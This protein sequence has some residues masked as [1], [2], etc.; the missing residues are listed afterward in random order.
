MAQKSPSEILVNAKEK[1]VTQKKEVGDENEM[2][3]SRE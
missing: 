3:G 1:I 2:I